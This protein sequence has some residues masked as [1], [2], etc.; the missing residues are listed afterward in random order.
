MNHRL[1][2]TACIAFLLLF[3]APF[4]IF[5]EEKTERL[6]ITVIQI[7]DDVKMQEEPHIWGDNIVWVETPD[8]K[9]SYNNREVK[10]Y[11][12]ITNKTI[13][14]TNISDEYEDYRY[15]NIFNDLVV[16]NLWSAHPDSQPNGFF[17]YNISTGFTKQVAKDYIAWLPKIYG[18]NIVFIESTMLIINE[19]KFNETGGDIGV[20]NIKTQEVTIICNAT[21]NQ[22]NPDIW[23]NYVVWEDRRNGQSDI[24]LYDL[25]TMKEVWITNTPEN[26]TEPRISGGNI[27]WKHDF[28][29]VEIYNIQNGSIFKTIDGSMHVID[30]NIVFVEFGDVVKIYNIT[31]GKEYLLSSELDDTYEWNLF[32]NKLV[33]IYHSFNNDDIYLLEFE[34]VN[35]TNG[36]GNNTDDGKGHNSLSIPS[37]TMSFL[38]MSIILIALIRRK[39]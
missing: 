2:I 35:G 10:L 27:I 17:I 34:I 1:S 21:D 11:N 18:D 39:N 12:I 7:T 37:A 9:P 14:L 22:T 33:Y 29:D 16:W 38:V 8:P 30:E 31:S 6:D 32:E 24:Y 5:A 4:S 28:T 20:Y 13:Q 15:P 19:T 36:N 25:N 23:E 3:Q 26:E